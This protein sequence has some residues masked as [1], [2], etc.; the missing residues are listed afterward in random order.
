MPATN[1]RPATHQ[2]KSMPVPASA[3]SLTDT[4]KVWQA[5][6][7]RLTPDV[8][9]AMVLRCE[10][11]PFVLINEDLLTKAF[12]ILLQLITKELSADAK[13]YLLISASMPQTED[14]DLALP[15]GYQRS[16][17]QLQTNIPFSG[18][19]VKAHHGE[20]DQIKNLI[21]PFGGEFTITQ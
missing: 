15:I 20:V 8:R 5:T 19:E 16:F 21:Q 13:L 11:L 12:S 18:K 9:T 2:L 1:Q 10:E 7:K 17:I 4:N 14:I 6:I 3:A